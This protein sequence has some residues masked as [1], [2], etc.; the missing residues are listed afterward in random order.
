[1]SVYLLQ[2]FSVVNLKVSSVFVENDKN[3]VVSFK[4]ARSHGVWGSCLQFCYLPQKSNKTILAATVPPKNC[5]SP[6]KTGWLYHMHVTVWCL[7]MYFF[8]RSLWLKRQIQNL[9]RNWTSIIGSWLF[10]SSLNWLDGHQLICNS[11][12]NVHLIV[13]TLLVER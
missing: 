6:Q 1:M 11:P 12:F 5:S 7:Y 9:T 13:F 8:A 10:L 4:L 3:V 2:C